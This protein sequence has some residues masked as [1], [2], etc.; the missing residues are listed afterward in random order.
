MIDWIKYA[1]RPPTEDGYYLVTDS[2]GTP[3]KAFWELGHQKY[4]DFS[5]VIWWAKVNWPE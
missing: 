2:G 5:S 3:F 4:W 1:D